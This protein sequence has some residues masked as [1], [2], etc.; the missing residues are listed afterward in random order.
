[1]EDA[2]IKLI[3]EQ[4]KYKLWQ[5]RYDKNAIPSE[6]IKQ[7]P[8]SNELLNWNT[9]HAHGDPKAVAAQDILCINFFHFPDCIVKKG[10]S[11]WNDCKKNQYLTLHDKL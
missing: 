1:M 10:Y 4:L 3:P 11:R 8:C 7:K 5:E 9:M 2:K 6:S